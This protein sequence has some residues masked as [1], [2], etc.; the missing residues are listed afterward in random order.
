[1]E[2]PVRLDGRCF[3]YGCESFATRVA[4][5][6]ED[7][8]GKLTL[9]CTSCYL[10]AEAAGNVSAGHVPTGMYADEAAAAVAADLVALAYDE[11]KPPAPPAAEAEVRA[12][13]L[14]VMLGTAA[15]SSAIRHVETR[16][17][18][19]YAEARA[20]VDAIPAMLPARLEAVGAVGDGLAD[21]NATP[22]SRAA[23]RDQVRR[24]LRIGHK[25]EAI[26]LVRERLRPMGLY[27]AKLY[28]E[29][30]Q[31][32]D[33]EELAKVT[34][35][36][37]RPLAVGDRVRIKAGVDARATG[38]EG[39]IDEVDDGDTRLPYH[40]EGLGWYKPDQVERID[41]RPELDGPTLGEA[42]RFKVGDRVE[43]VGTPAGLDG[44][45]QVLG[46]I[47]TVQEVGTI[48]RDNF[49]VQVDNGG[50]PWWYESSALKPAPI[51][52][53]DRVR[54]VG[55]PYSLDYK[56]ELIGRRGK[57]ED[58]DGHPDGAI[59]VRHGAAHSD[60]WWYSRSAL[61]S[62]A[63]AASAEVPDFDVNPDDWF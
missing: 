7:D 5:Y 48:D 40:V 37:V 52:R 6:R 11:L 3:T 27:A 4:R 39:A 53:G 29:E 34:A 47:G 35:E 32:Q 8:P 49:R 20:F 62:V 61:R 13:A 14:R 55:T 41:E 1:M 2:R 57:V 24:L 19:G 18:L 21:A 60:Y 45:A 51:G 38:E 10:S 26:K 15:E 22:A 59:R 25:I 30:I 17:G 33:R 63:P 43:V 28:V 54:I 58:V 31:R 56:T 44:M 46:R 9:Y 16:L 12:E 23:L 42:G 50:F 36:P